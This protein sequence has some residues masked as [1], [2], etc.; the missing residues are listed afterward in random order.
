MSDLIRLRVISEFCRYIK[1]APS[2]NQRACDMPPYLALL[3]LDDSLHHIK[4]N[5][6]DIQ[7]ISPDDWKSHAE[8]ERDKTDDAIGYSIWCVIDGLGEPDFC[9]LVIS[10]GS[11]I[12][13]YTTTLEGSDVQE[14]SAP[15]YLPCFFDLDVAQH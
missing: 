4:P 6:S 15:D 1:S 10:V 11:E 8:K 7:W 12:N 5:P 2:L 9:L 3:T 13:F 14:V